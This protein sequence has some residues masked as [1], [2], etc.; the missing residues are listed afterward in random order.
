MAKIIRNI[1]IVILVYISYYCY[2]NFFSINT[3][4]GKYVVEQ[5]GLEPFLA[6]T[7]YGDDFLILKSDFTFISSYWGT[8]TWDVSSD[9]QNGTRIHLIYENGKSSYSANIK[10]QYLSSPRVIMDIDM[11]HYMGKIN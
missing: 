8:G 11:N 9:F 7:P 6:E 10:R 2:H 1:L 5:Q 4:V 3:I